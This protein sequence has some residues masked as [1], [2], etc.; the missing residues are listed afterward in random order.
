VL[1]PFEIQTDLPETVSLYP[2][3]PYN[4]SINITNHGGE[5]LNATLYYTVQT[6]NCTV[7][8]TPSNGSIF[9]VAAGQT[10]SIPV[11]ITVYIDGYSAN[12]TA[13]IDWWIERG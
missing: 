6:V 9:L 11:A 1:E 3:G 10:T 12:G 8:I 4:Y 7:E 5:P 13:T 2:G